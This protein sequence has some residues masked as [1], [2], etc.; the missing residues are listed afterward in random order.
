MLRREE[1]EK[2]LDKLRVKD[3]CKHKVAAFGALPEKVR[4]AGR[5]LLGRDP[6]GKPFKGWQKERKAFEEAVDVL[7]RLAAR[8]RQKVFAVL[9]PRLAAHLEGAWQLLARLPYEV[10]FNR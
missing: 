8:D 3:W 5:A 7:Q 10:D 4:A 2:R 6:Q 1:A 9:F